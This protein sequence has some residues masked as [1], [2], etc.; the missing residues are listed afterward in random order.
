[1]SKKTEKYILVDG[2]HGRHDSKGNL[3]IYRAGV[4]GHNMLSLTKAEAR[5]L[6][7]KVKS[8]ASVRAELSAF[9]DEEEEDVLQE[10]VKNVG[11]VGDEDEDDEEDEEEDWDFSD[12]TGPDAITIINS[13]TSVEDL[14]TALESEK[15]SKNRV[16][17]M[18]AINHRIEAIE[19][20]EEEEEDDDEG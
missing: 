18:N 2:K 12:M 4:K 19:D 20:E 9:D 10:D 11:E 16:T 8:L 13:L 6:G 17:V 1:M 15:G 14:E 7:K 3:V 5:A